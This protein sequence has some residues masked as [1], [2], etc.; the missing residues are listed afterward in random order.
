MSATLSRSIKADIC[1]DSMRSVRRPKAAARI[2]MNSVC[3]MSEVLHIQVQAPRMQRSLP[4]TAARFE[5]C[6]RSWCP[7]GYWE[8]GS[9]SFSM[10]CWGPN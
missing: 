3:Q 2:I 5:P 7:G 9:I 6:S 1:M 4:R 8:L 10:A